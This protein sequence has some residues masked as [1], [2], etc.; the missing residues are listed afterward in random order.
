MSNGSGPAS[1]SQ[2]RKNRVSISGRPSGPPPSP[3]RPTSNPHRLSSAS[4]SSSQSAATLKNLVKQMQADTRRT[5]A[6]SGGGNRPPKSYNT[7]TGTQASVA[8]TVTSPGSP[9]AQSR[10]GTSTRNSIVIG[11]SASIASSAAGGGISKDAQDKMTLDG[12][13]LIVQLAALNKLLATSGLQTL[14][15]G[16]AP[17]TVNPVSES[18]P[19]SFTDLR[20]ALLAVRELH[21]HLLQ[22][23]RNLDES[24][25]AQRLLR[26]ENKSLTVRLERQ[27]REEERRERERASVESRATAAEAALR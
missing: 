9:L 10:A 1:P 8:S 20:D 13:A 15:K 11:R 23:Y 17:G 4:S 22:S 3:G 24:A 26:L 18:R 7:S 16:L 6:G 14:P 19:P 25:Q 12:A 27:K 21:S 5:A 2:R